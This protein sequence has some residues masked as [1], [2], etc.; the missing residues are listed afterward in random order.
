MSR[1]RKDTETVV[2][3]TPERPKAPEWVA[4]WHQ[5]GFK[6]SRPDDLCTEPGCTKT[7]REHI[8]DFLRAGEQ[9]ERRVV[10]L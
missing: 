9:I 4:P 1:V 5:P 10:K 3:E 2:D 7:V 8:D 6:L